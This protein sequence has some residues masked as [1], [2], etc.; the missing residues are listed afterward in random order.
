[1]RAG[2]RDLF[3]KR[4]RQL[5]AAPEFLF[6][7][8]IA[9][10]L[11]R[12]AAPGW[13]H[14][15]LPMGELRTP[16]TAGRL[17]RMGVKPGWP[18]FILLSPNGLAHFLELK[19][20]GGRLSPHQQAFAHWCEGRCPFACVDSFDAALGELKGWGALKVSINLEGRA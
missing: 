20:K 6:H 8:M 17:K 5:P 11:G 15:H 14:T 9:D 13:L 1:M 2:Q 10:V 4:V 3:T 19:R 12:W 18:D 16:A 7:V